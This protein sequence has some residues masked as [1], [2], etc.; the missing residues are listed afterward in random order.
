MELCM[1]ESVS[2]QL[3]DLEVNLG[4]CHSGDMSAG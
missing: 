3:R 2:V 4:A 1:Q